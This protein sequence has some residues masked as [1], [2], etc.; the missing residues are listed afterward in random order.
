MFDA[1]IG[2]VISLSSHMRQNVAKSPC[3]TH[4]LNQKDCT[5]N[6]EPKIGAPL[7]KLIKL[8]QSTLHHTVLRM[9]NNK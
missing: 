6:L 3:I 2:S 8:V 7:R 9:W 4:P 5:T 1:N